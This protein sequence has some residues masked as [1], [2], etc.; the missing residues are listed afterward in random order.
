MEQET[1]P[2][3]FP[4]DAC[5]DQGGHVFRPAGCRHCR[6]TGYLGRLGLFEL[7]ETNEEIREMACERGASTVIKQAAVQSGMRTLRQDGWQK[8]LEGVTS[9]DEVLRVTAGD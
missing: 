1:A 2:E 8:V 4:F 9:I 3:D 7:L 5:R 6:N